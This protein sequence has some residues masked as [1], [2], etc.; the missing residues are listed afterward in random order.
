MVTR[1]VTGRDRQSRLDHRDTRHTRGRHRTP[2]VRSVSSAPSVRAR[3]RPVRDAGGEG[4]PVARSRA[5]SRCG[6]SGVRDPPG[7]GPAR[8]PT[9]NRGDGSRG[10]H[11]GSRADRR[12]PQRDGAVPAGQ[13]ANGRGDHRPR[14]LRVGL[15]GRRDGVR[16]RRV[17][18]A[19]PGPGGR[20]PGDD[21]RGRVDGRRPGLV[22]PR[23]GG[24]RRGLRSR[25]RRHGRTTRD[26]TPRDRHALLPSVPGGRRAARSGPPLPRER[27][28]GAGGGVRCVAVR[29]RP[30]GCA[31]HR[32]DAGR[33]RDGRQRP[34]AVVEPDGGRDL[35]AV[36]R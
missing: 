27:S 30:R 7:F 16:V 6:N 2:G 24:A 32:G 14:V 33:V 11:R 8:G 23:R 10:T 35:R 26:R 22:R 20:G 3:R 1:G 28:T 13:A 17:R 31:R 12:A 29:R 5:R 34:P 18:G 15:P 4:D 36:R 9:A 19:R 21:R 25:S